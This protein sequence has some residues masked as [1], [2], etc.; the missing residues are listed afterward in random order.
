VKV[1]DDH[2]SSEVLA[3]RAAALVPLLREQA[4][5]AERRGR[6]TDGVA[7]AVRKAGLLDLFKPR[8]YGG[9]EA[10]LRTAVSVQIELG[11]GCSSTAWVVSQLNG[12]AIV[13]CLFPEKVR[14]EVFAR[15]DASVATSLVLPPRVSVKRAPGG[16]ALSGVWPFCTGCLH[17]S[18]VGVPAPLLGGGDEDGPRDARGIGLYLLPTSQIEI[19]DDWRVSGLCGTGSN[20]VAADDAFVPEHHVL[21]F[22]PALRADFPFEGLDGPLYRMPMFSGLLLNAASSALGMAQSAMEEFKAQL[23]GRAVAY[24]FYSERREA[25]MTH[26]QIAE[27]AMKLDAAR[28][29]LYRGVDD[30]EGHAARGEVMPEPRRIRA[31]MDAAYAAALCREAIEI[32]FDASGGSSLSL[33]N[34]IQRIARDARALC[35]H[36]A[37]SLSPALETYG[38]SLLGLPTN[39]PLT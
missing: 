5:E 4:L 16:Y 38:R 12:S 9:L 11:R 33:S 17:A 30:V 7:H 10:N 32:L 24:T 1:N 36:G 15:P 37:Y 34:P 28:L 39:A 8:R 26:L 22:T 14:A 2:V 3:L 21:D 31:R 13:A 25:A 18:W 27:A 29:L 23:P 35:Q 6:L 20:S 19:K